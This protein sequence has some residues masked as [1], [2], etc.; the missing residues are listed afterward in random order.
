MEGV[1]LTG[2]ETSEPESLRDS[3][4]ETETKAGTVKHNGSM[5][6]FT[7]P[8]ESRQAGTTRPSALMANDLLTPAPTSP[9]G[10]ALPGTGHELDAFLGK[11]FEEQPVWVRL[12]ESIRD[13]F[14]PVKLPPLQL[15]SKPIPVPDRMAVKANPW[16]IGI[17]STLNIAI[18]LLA[19][20]L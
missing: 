1:K 16:A 18:L 6:L 8:L 17:S 19:I 12:W 3:V 9:Q 14:F 2:Y 7:D 11:A 20:W 5:G 4:S 15:T 10:T 13:V